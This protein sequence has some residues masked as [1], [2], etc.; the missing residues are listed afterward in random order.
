MIYY[1][2]SDLNLGF[3]LP[4]HQYGKWGVYNHFV[5]LLKFQLLILR[6]AEPHLF[7]ADI[8]IDFC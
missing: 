7:L 1:L 6:F 4:W 8:L 2:A 5:I 3:P